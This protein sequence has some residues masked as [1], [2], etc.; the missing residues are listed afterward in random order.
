MQESGSFFLV[1][2]HSHTCSVYLPP[3]THKHY[4]EKAPYGP[5][6]GTCEHWFWSSSGSFYYFYSK[7]TNGSKKNNKLTIKRNRSLHCKTAVRTGARIFWTST[8]S[9]VPCPCFAECPLGCGAWRRWSFSATNIAQIPSPQQHF[10]VLFVVSFLYPIEHMLLGWM[11]CVCVHRT[12]SVLKAPQQ[13]KTPILLRKKNMENS[14]SLFVPTSLT[15]NRTHFVPS[16]RRSFK[17]MFNAAAPAS[18]HA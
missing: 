10:H 2:P 15:S 9:A 16:A 14:T 3:S 12:V 11:G 18:C 5:K 7:F 4:G 8:S 6:A 1:H 13:K 17:I